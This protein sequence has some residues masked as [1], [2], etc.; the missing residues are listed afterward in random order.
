MS[1]AFGDFQPEIFRKLRMDSID[2]EIGETAYLLVNYRNA[3]RL[4]L[5]SNVIGIGL[6]VVNCFCVH[7]SSSLLCCLVSVLLL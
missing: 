2:E 4:Y 7:V 3:I 6:Y 5:T 1:S